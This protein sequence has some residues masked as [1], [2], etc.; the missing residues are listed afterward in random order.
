MESTVFLLLA[1]LIVF[2]VVVGGI[3]FALVYFLREFRR[4]NDILAE[5]NR[6]L[7]EQGMPLHEY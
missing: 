4:R 6:I 7:K 1:S 2:V 5:R 3:I